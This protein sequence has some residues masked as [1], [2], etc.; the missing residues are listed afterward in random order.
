VPRRSSTARRAVCRRSSRSWPRCRPSGSWSCLRGPAA[1]RARTRSIGEGFIRVLPGQYYDAETGTNYNYYRDYDP[2]IGRYEQSDPIGL[3]GGVNTYAYTS[4]GQLAYADPVGLQ[5]PAP[6]PWPPIV[7]PPPGIPGY[8][9]DPPRTRIPE[10]PAPSPIL[11]LVN[12]ALCLPGIVYLILEMCKPGP[13]C[14][15]LHKDDTDTCNAISRKRGP[16]KGQ[17]CHASASERYAACL[18]GQPIPP[19]N[20]RNN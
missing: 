12:P 1:R 19:L 14:E 13:D 8:P 3:D 15:K 17:A 9:G 7:V 16:V 4:N 10:P 5:V 2:T 6:P 11:C 18:S 20:T